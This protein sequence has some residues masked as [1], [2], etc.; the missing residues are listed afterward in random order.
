MQSLC[1]DFPGTRCL[2]I[3]PLHT[4]GCI[5]RGSYTW[6]GLAYSTCMGTDVCF[7]R[8]L[9]AFGAYVNMHAGTLCNATRSAQPFTI[10]SPNASQ[11][12]SV[13]GSIRVQESHYVSSA[14]CMAS[15]Q[16]C[17]LCRR[18]LP[19]IYY[20]KNFCISNVALEK[21]LSNKWYFI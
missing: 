1:N 8:T 7:K 17:G 21:I 2:H 4:S 12:V 6:P 13:G 3:H 20:V 15:V 18:H 9:C 19:R 16:Q 14:F 10:T 11:L 5:R